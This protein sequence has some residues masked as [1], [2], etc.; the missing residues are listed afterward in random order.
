[1]RQA[2]AVLD[3]LFGQEHR[4]CGNPRDKE[5]PDEIEGARRA[6]VTDV[7]ERSRGSPRN[8]GGGP[9][10]FE[11]L[12]QPDCRP[13]G[14]RV[15]S[16]RE[17]EDRMGAYRRDVEFRVVLERAGFAEREVYLTPGE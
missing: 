7:P 1:M 14:Q 10:E 6:V 12:L 4:R 16:T 5:L 3:D 2:V 15:L 9:G 11:Q 13:T 17:E 8:H